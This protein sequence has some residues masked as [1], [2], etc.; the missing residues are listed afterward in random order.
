MVLRNYYIKLDY[1][2]CLK[3]RYKLYKIFALV[4]FNNLIKEVLD[5]TILL[6]AFLV[7]M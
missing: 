1:T 6:S 4:L 3:E 2:I 5:S 7:E